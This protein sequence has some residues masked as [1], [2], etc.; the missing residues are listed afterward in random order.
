VKIGAVSPDAQTWKILAGEA[1]VRRCPVEVFDS[2]IGAVESGPRLVFADWPVDRAA[3]DMLEGLRKAKA[4]QPPVTVIALLPRGLPDHKRRAL[5]AG[6]EDVL[7][8]PL[9]RLE[10]AAEISAFLDDV[11]SIP[12]AKRGVYDGLLT[13]ELVGN[14]P[15][16]TR[17]LVELSKAAASDANVLLLGETGTGKDVFAKAIHALSSRAGA[18]FFPVNMSALT[19]ELIESRLFGHRKG[20]FTGADTDHEGIFSAVG[21][22][23]LFLDEIGD[24]DETLQVRLLRVVENRQF[25]RLGDNR[26]LEF[27]GRLVAA[28]WRDLD[29]EVRENRFRHDLLRRLDQLRISLPPLRNRKSDIPL[30]ARSFLRRHSPE[31][32]IEVSRSAMAFLEDYHY[33][34][35]VRELEN[36]IAKA[37]VAASPGDWILPKHLPAEIRHGAAAEPESRHHVLRIPESAPYGEARTA[38]MEMIDGIYLERLLGEKAGNQSAAAEAAGIDRKTF[39]TRLDNSKKWIR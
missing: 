11:P 4:H 36:A 30:L 2:L 25:Q 15:E 1:A 32:V 6:A 20:A 14:T 16:F 39:S 17:S 33:P 29:T 9:D 18:P 23:T 35:N 31:K 13:E 12:A 3:G 21:A 26:F 37:I 8:A 5:S 22:G 38:A 28:T 27:R 24:L 10:V 34:G 7:F 19:K